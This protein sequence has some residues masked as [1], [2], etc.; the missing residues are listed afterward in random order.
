MKDNRFWR[1]LAA[2]LCT[3][4]LVLQPLPLLTAQTR[5]IHWTETGSETQWRLRYG[6]CDYGYFVAL[7]PGVVGHN[8]LPP[9]PNH[10]FMVALPDVGRTSYALN[11]RR[12]FIWVDATY[13]VTG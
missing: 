13:D 6:N 5:G 3:P 1:V 12:R 2:T 11:E 4:I 9:S 7:A 10:G 8:T